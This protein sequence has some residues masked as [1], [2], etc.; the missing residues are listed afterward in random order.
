MEKSVLA[1]VIYKSINSTMEEY[2]DGYLDVLSYGDLSNV[3]CEGRIDL[4]RVA[5]D[6]LKAINSYSRF[7]GSGYEMLSKGE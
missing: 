1:E 3:V 2:E 4:I 5:D 7:S 6:V